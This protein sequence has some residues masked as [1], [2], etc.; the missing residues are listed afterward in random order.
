MKSE[1][2]SYE[3]LQF[4]QKFTDSPHPSDSPNSP[5]PPNSSKSLESRGIQQVL[6]NGSSCPVFGYVNE[7]LKGLKEY[8]DN[9]TLVHE[10]GTQVRQT[11]SSSYHPV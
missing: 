3:R 8:N 9:V 11:R 6:N 10:V 2:F 5:D 4:C 1:S 7:T